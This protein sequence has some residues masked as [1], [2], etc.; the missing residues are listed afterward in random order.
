MLISKKSINVL[1][2]NKLFNVAENLACGM[3]VHEVAEAINRLMKDRNLEHIHRS[4]TLLVLSGEVW[5]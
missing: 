4:L 1:V 3:F 5:Q 2:L